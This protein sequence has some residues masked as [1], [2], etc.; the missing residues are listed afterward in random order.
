VTTAPTVAAPPTETGTPLPSPTA[1][2]DVV[3][4]LADPDVPGA[5]KV[6]LVEHG[7]PADAA[8]LDRFGKALRDGGYLPLTFEAQ[9]LA[10]AQDQRGNVT[11]NITI[12]SAGP[13]A[14]GRDLSFPME[15]SPQ[16]DA[17]QLTRKTA[18]LLLALGPQA[19]ATPTG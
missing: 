18:D 7:T 3:S 4:R 6:G 2:T 19:P 17:W 8:A 15:F 10:W 11:A 5:D 16:Q 14:A 1:L 12:N 9:D 13:Q